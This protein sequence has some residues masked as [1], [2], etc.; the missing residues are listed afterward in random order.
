[1]EKF[2]WAYTCCNPFNKPGHLSKSKKKKLRPILPWMIEKFPFL[3]LGGKICNSCRLQLAQTTVEE[4]TLDESDDDVDDSYTCHQEQ[5]ESIN[6]CLKVIGETPDVKKKIVHT[7]YQ[8]EKLSK[9]K[10][11][12][13]KA[14]L[15]SVVP[16]QINDGCEIIE[17]LKEKFHSSIERSQQATILTILPKSWS[18]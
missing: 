4:T 14:L 11:A 18:V 17:Q 2:Q 13:A 5:L 8:K 15:P 1:M 3:E 9:I 6:E 10:D 16:T 7:G 12:T